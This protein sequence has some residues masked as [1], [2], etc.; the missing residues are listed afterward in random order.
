MRT[1]LADGFPFVFGFTVYENFE[2]RQVARTGVLN[3]PQ[4]AER[5]VG[6]HAV[7]AVGYIDAAKR[8]IVRNSWGTAWGKKGYFSMPFDYLVDSDLAA[9]FWTIRLVE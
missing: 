2:S 3:M 9:D 5:V 4:Q 8:F 6:G 1:C 7:M